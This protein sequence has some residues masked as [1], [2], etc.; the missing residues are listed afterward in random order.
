MD[1]P[2]NDNPTPRIKKGFIQVNISCYVYDP[3]LTDAEKCVE[4]PNVVGD[5]AD[6]QPILYNV[7]AP[8]SGD[9]SPEELY[10]IPKGMQQEVF[11]VMS[12]TCKLIREHTPDPTKM[13]MLRQQQALQSETKPLLLDHKGDTIN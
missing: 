10:G 6:M 4:N 9:I 7:Y 12:Q 5:F 3:R 8:V 1:S 2:A 11:N 13:V